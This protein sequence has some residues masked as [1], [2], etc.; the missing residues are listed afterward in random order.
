LTHLRRDRALP[1]VKDRRTDER[2]PW[3]RRSPQTSNLPLS[4]NLASNCTTRTWRRGGGAP[5]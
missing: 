5:V 2:H 3:T 4:E 1:G